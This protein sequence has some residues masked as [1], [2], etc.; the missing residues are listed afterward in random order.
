M[1]GA[2]MDLKS[3]CFFERYDPVFPVDPDCAD[4]LRFILIAHF[5]PPFICRF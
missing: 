2:E 4:L 5:V 1:R 3:R